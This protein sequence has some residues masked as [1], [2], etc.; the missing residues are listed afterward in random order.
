VLALALTALLAKPSMAQGYIGFG[1][2]SCGSWTL[3]RTNRS[4]AALVYGA[5]IAGYVSGVNA[6][7]TLDNK[8]PDFLRHTDG[9]GV[10][11]WVDNYCSSS[12][13]STLLDASIK[14]INT[15]RANAG[16]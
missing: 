9:A 14:L 16:H 3:E 12:P 8:R 7:N 5:W 6:A 1:N 11:A 4:T 10:V 15:L 2:E 13:L